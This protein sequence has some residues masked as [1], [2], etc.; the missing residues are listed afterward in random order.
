MVFQKKTNIQPF[1]AK[2]ISPWASF[3]R[4]I[5]FASWNHI[6]AICSRP[7][8]NC[9]TAFINLYIQQHYIY[10]VTSIFFIGVYCVLQP[11]RDETDLDDNVCDN[12]LIFDKVIWFINLPS[13]KYRC[14]SPR[15]KVSYSFEDQKRCQHC[16]SVKRHR[17]ISNSRTQQLIQ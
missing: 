2:N 16:Y 5:Y 9:I 17:F 11:L 14:K 6:F 8:Y 15:F 13:V 3:Y 7:L 10:H 1:S 12:P 4:E